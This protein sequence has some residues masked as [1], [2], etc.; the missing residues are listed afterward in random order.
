MKKIT[1]IFLIM[2][3][4]ITIGCNEHVHE[5]VNGYCECGV[6]EMAEDDTIYVDKIEI[7]GLSEMTEGDEQTLTVNILPLNT[8]N[9]E[10][11]WSSSD[12]TIATVENGKVFALREGV[13]T[14]KAASKDGSNKECEYVITVNKLVIEV[15]KIEISGNNEMLE[16]EEQTLT[17][18]VFPNKATNK[19]VVWSS[20][21]ETIA[22]VDNGKVKTLKD[23]KVTIKAESINK[24]YGEIEINIDYIPE[25]YVEDIE[26]FVGESVE[27]NINIVKGNASDLEIDIEGTRVEYKDGLF[28]GIKYGETEV[29]V[30]IKGVTKSMFIN[31]KSIGIKVKNESLDVDIFEELELDI[32]YPKYLGYRL[33]YECLNKDIAA[34]K[35]GTVYPKATGEAKIRIYFEEDESIR[36]TITV[37]VTSDPIKIIESLHINEPLM[38][39]KV[40]SY[41]NTKIDQAVMGSVS[42][43]Y[44]GKLNLIENIVDITDNMYVGLTA[45]PEILEEL[46]ET[47]KPRTG[48]KLEEIKYITYH[49]T[50]NNTK[51]ANADMHARYM[52]GDYNKSARAR[53]WHYTVD[54]KSVIHHVPD[55]EVTW[56]GDTYTA[57]SQSI[58][59]ETCVDSGSNLHLVWQRMGKLCA[60]LIMKYDLSINSI[61]QHY[62]WNQKNCPQ[63][64]RMNNLYSYAISLVE[65]ELLV[66]KALNGYTLK[67]ESLNPEY[68]SDEGIIIKAPESPIQVGYKV[69]ISN[70]D[71]YNETV[72]LYSN[73]NPLA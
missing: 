16:G 2:F 52:I 7:T 12:K 34:V 64:L 55:D 19:E 72:T 13:V 23:G 62:D 56:Q 53:S 44:F 51:N 22:T 25:F 30:T 14:I 9:K 3:L 39:K 70:K 20:S 32:D 36:R 59:I 46:D 38:K 61:K 43:Y 11:T 6:N 28:T 18:N 27:P 48:V 37:K 67:F 15:E 47:G 45:T 63:T 17:L 33:M 21:D 24:V 10:V 58:G 60:D 5:F 31:V 8:T 26:M 40:T 50:G 35:D 73:L 57:Y 41:G 29:R 69:T 1:L 54:E 42:R 66:K 4:F 65:G 71:G 68:V 49:D